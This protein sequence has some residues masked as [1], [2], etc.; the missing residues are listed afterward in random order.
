MAPG[1]ATE[2]FRPARG[3]GVLLIAA[4]VLEI[5][6]MAH[7]PSVHAS[8]ARAALARLQELAP[9]SAWVHGILIALMLLGFFALS[10]FALWR[11]LTR[12]R[13]R[14]GLTAYAIGVMAMTGAAL[15]SGFIAPQLFSLFDDPSAVD[16]TLIRVPLRLC[17]LMNRALA[18]LGAVAM[19]A[20]I[21]AWSL[22]LLTGQR[23]ERA[24][25][26]LGVAVGLGCAV[27]LIAGVLHL[28]VHGMMLTVVLQGIWTI[29]TGVLLLGA[30]RPDPL[31]SA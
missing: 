19:S 6:T 9:L 12:W 25:G 4:S 1:A 22:D 31:R 5:A 10:E 30:T 14:A 20:G 29:A 17:A 26:G 15:V 16:P 11:G 3:A 18:D 13:V 24:V 8:D 7:H 28:D 27:A 2:A 21:F 23:A